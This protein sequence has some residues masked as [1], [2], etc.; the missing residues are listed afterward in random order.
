LLLQAFQRHVRLSSALA[1]LLLDVLLVAVEGAGVLLLEEA[2]SSGFADMLEGCRGILGDWERVLVLM[3]DD[4]SG[5]TGDGFG[6][7]PGLSGSGV[8]GTESRDL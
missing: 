1:A 2:L 8:A 5:C 7:L 3:G 4:G 6:R